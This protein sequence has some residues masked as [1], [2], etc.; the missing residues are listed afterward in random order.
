LDRSEIIN[1]NSER[2]ESFMMGT[3]EIENSF[4]KNGFKKC[5]NLVSFAREKSIKYRKQEGTINITL[6]VEGNKG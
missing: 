3:Y 1:N 4:A 6:C 5:Q 2:S